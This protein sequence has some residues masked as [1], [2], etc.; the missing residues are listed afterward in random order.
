MSADL[1]KEKKKT[2][3]AGSLFDLILNK[4]SLFGVKI[5]ESL[6][7]N[8]ELFQNNIPIV[9]LRCIE[10]IDQNGLKTEN[11]FQSNVKKSDYKILKDAFDKGEVVDEVG[12]E[13]PFIASGLLRHYFSEL[14]APII[15]HDDSYKFV[16]ATGMKDRAVALGHFRKLYRSLPPVNQTILCYFVC[17]LARYNAYWEYNKSTAQILADE[18]GYALLRHSESTENQKFL[19]SMTLVIMIEEFEFIFEQSKYQRDTMTTKPVFGGALSV[20]PLIDGIPFVI[21]KTLDFLNQYVETEGVLRISGSSATIVEIKDTFEKGQEVD[22][23]KLETP[24]HVAAGVLK[25]YLRE[26]PEPLL[27]FPLYDKFIQSVDN[28]EIKLSELL[29]KLPA[30]NQLVLKHLMQFLNKVNQNSDTNKMP[31]ANI[32]TTIGPN[33]LRQYSVFESDSSMIQDVE[34][35]I[36]CIKSIVDNFNTLFKE[37]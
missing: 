35:V 19:F 22:F 24:V 25:L 18:F 26:L 37:K 13:S 17:F 30:I 3:S 23:S 34:K 27:I 5:D 15:P 8:P 32:A 7:K 16:K 20:Q 31:A 28:P 4:K 36:K 1:P 6:K 33:L 21:K 9:L 2:K 11:L 14:P 29:K 12:F 10:Y